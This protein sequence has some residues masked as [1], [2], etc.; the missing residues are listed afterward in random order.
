MKVLF[1]CKYNAGRSRMAA[2]FF[3]KFS[4]KNEAF[5]RGIGQ[6]PKLPA[7]RKGIET[8]A[9]V[10]KELGI[11]IPLRLGKGVTK[12]DVEN[13]DKVIVLLDSK[14]IHI[15]PKY[16]ADS[17]KTEYYPIRDSDA[18]T[19]DFINQQRE[20]RDIIKQMVLKMVQKLQ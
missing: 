5:S 4:K 3:N 1:I 13:A 11:K 12:K 19:K 20:N 14:Q 16:V 17:P 6:N 9:A 15:L 7:S 18:R 10:M 8:T 2:A